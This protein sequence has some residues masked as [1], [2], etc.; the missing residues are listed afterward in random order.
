MIFNRPRTYLLLPTVAVLGVSSTA[1]FAQNSPPR[2]RLSLDADWRFHKGDF[3]DSKPLGQGYVLQKWRWKAGKDEAALT[4][5]TSGPSWKDA[6]PSDDVFGRQP[7]FAWFR[8]TLPAVD[9]LKSQP[10][11][12]FSG[13]DDNA[14]VY[15][16]GQKLIYHE[17]WDRA[18]EVSLQ[19]AWKAGVPNELA[20]LVENG[21][22]TG[23]I[24][25]A[26]VRIGV[27]VYSSATTVAFDDSAWRRLDL[28]HD[29]GIEGPF[30]ID[31]PGE[32]AKLPWVGIGWYRKEFTVAAAEK[33]R[34]F[35]LEMD[36]AMSNAQVWLN[37][38]LIGGW[39]Y[40]YASWSLD[41]TPAI[42]FGGK[43]TLAIRLDNPP[44][45]SR[46]YPGGGIYRDVWLTKTA[47]LHVAH[48]GTQVSSDVV[49]TGAK[50]QAKITVKNEAATATDFRLVNTIL[51]SQ[52]KPVGEVQSRLRLAAN[53]SST[54]AASLQIA[55][56]QKW[57]IEKPYLYTL[58]TKVMRGT[59]VIDRYETPF[60]VRTI[61]FSVKN[62]FQLNG[63][64]VQMNGVCLHH[65]LGALG[66]AW[67]KRAAQRQ[68]EIMKSMGVNA[69]RTSHNPPAPGFLDLCD[70]MGFVV[71]DEFTDTWK[72][73]KKRNGYATLFDEWA[74]KDMRAMVVRDRNH[75]SVVFWSI[76]NEIPE[77][78]DTVNGQKLEKM[79]VDVAHTEDP[80]RPAT[81]GN[82]QVP[83]GYNGWQ[84]IT[85]VFG[86]NYKPWE[87]AKFR[88][89]NPNIPLYG[90]ETS[91]A[92][93][94]RGEYFFPLDRQTS[95]VQVN[96]YDVRAV[97]WGS[98]PDRE[99]QGQQENPSVFGEFVWTGFDYLGEPT[100]YNSDTTTLSNYADPVERAKAEAQL[101]ELGRVKVPSRSSYFGIVDLAGFPKD[102]YYLYQA[103]WRPNLP[104]AHILPHWNWSERVGQVTPVFVYTSGDE[105]ELFLNGKS[106]GRKKKEPMNY[107][108]RWD[109]VVYEPGTVRVVA[110]K[111]GK[112]WATDTVTTTGAAT[113][114]MLEADRSRIANDGK[115]LSFVTVKIADQ[116]GVMVPRSMN[117]L[118]FSLTGPGEIVATDNGNAIDLT[119]FSSKQRKAFNGL[120]LVIVK[121]AKGKSGDIVLTATT[122]GL[123][124]SSI[125]IKTAK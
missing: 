76:G 24:G 99:F 118:T 105:A 77:Q 64:R 4:E 36:G 80:T 73:A 3:A 78:G 71:M 124:A 7:G 66:A 93:S 5:D 94:S 46:W 49:G 40:G 86:Y 15:L 123:S 63:Q 6:G 68:L 45:S 87:Y 61:A 11:L 9:A 116:K 39:P 112:E 60:G 69:I 29:W 70:R 111:N 41:L 1:V 122:P 90:S 53:S 115:D 42:Q 43:N 14:T 95:N 23:G 18:F 8:A 50:V 81:S 2:E 91:S 106:L 72:Q 33:G 79:L 21:A 37:G 35:Q 92:I 19:N 12:R 113:K 98:T 27:P 59:Q 57:S 20:V 100:P 84:K 31:L 119:T 10:L 56:A 28:P 125:R 109:D 51:D 25:E 110:Y 67:N 65:D 88:N 97:P 47:P 38:K 74:T 121:A 13:V 102:R 108:L 17:G 104:M 75:P 101:R 96:S 89:A 34:R 52:L 85:D 26:G 107:R 62:G 82:D 83:S 54:S 22:N 120:A 48:W 30:D 117:D 44:E 103:H 55:R 16:N 32:T 114:I 58:V